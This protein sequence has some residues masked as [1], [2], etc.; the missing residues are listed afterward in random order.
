MTMLTA[1][2][3]GSPVHE[4]I[5]YNSIQNRIGN[6]NDTLLQLRIG[7]PQDEVLEVMGKPERSE[8]YSWGSAWLYRTAMTSGIYGTEDTDFTPVVFDPDGTVS[9]W[10]RNYFVEQ[11]KKYEVDI[12][13]NQ[14]TSSGSD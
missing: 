12:D 13:I 9:G 8:G 10:G 2:C 11:A 1:S 7:M 6:N 4:T 14:K 5:K 3:V